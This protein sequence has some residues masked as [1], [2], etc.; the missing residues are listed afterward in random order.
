LPSQNLLAPLH[1]PGP[2]L[3]SIPEEAKEATL[4][5]AATNSGSMALAAA[6]MAL[7]KPSGGQAGN[8]PSS[9]DGSGRGGARD[10]ADKM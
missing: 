4:Q 8:K 3:R 6:E 5:L 2:S 1:P 9:S 10:G 7:S